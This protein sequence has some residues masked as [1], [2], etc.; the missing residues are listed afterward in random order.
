MEKF[1]EKEYDVV[2][3]DIKMPKMDGI[4][5]LEKA[6]Q[7]KPDSTIIIISGHALPR[8]LLKVEHQLN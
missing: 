3:C 2:L 1:S 8:P 5:Y 7:M 4:E 6:K